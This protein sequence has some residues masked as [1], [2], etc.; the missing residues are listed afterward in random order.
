MKTD[1]FEIISTVLNENSA[2]W[3]SICIDNITYTV[4]ALGYTQLELPS[5]GYAFVD[6][7]YVAS[8]RA[9]FLRKELCE[10][11]TA[12]GFETVTCDLP[13]KNLAYY[14][15]LGTAL[16]STLIANELFGT[17]MALEIVGVHGIF[18]NEVSIEAVLKKPE[19]AAFC[20]TCSIC[21]AV[22]PTGCISADSF[23]RNRC[24]RS[25]QE[26]A[27]LTDKTAAKAMGTQLWGCDICQRCCPFNKHLPTRAM[28]EREKELYLIDNLYANFSLGKKGCE[29]YRDILGGNYLRPSK[30]MA[31]TLNVMA[32]SSD[33]H[34]YILCAEKMKSHADERV[35]T[36][37]ERL[38]DKIKNRS[39]SK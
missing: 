26:S 6:S 7:Y 17:R 28:T 8:N 16:R 1:Y 25:V 5:E 24:I 23:E 19:M 33:P 22:C 12:A 36:A 13:Y 14:S 31:L 3:K 4:F 30:L 15:G 34:K 21:E 9:Y 20:R 29:P 38:I 11:L 27:D 18:A 35:R 32:N 10:K 37:A 39:D 2:Q